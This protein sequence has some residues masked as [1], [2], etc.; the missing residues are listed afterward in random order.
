[1]SEPTFESEAEVKRGEAAT[2]ILLSLLVLFVAAVVV[3]W[4]S[5]ALAPDLPPMLVF[6]VAQGLVVLAGV[7]LLLRRR[8]TRWRD[9][10]LVG[11]QPVDVPRALGALVLMVAVAYALTLLLELIAPGVMEAHTE[12]LTR[13]ARMLVG[14]LPFGF[15]IAGMLFVGF[16]EEAFA[17]G[18]LLRRSRQLLGGIWM[19][20]LVSSILFGLGHAYQ[21]WAGVVQTALIGVVLARL[22]LY[23]GTLWPAILAHAAL[24]T[25]T[26][27][28]AHTAGG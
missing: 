7:A 19:P 28:L 11:L 25:L 15:V 6:I 5:V 27:A 10:G 23:W 3:G 21:G 14:D 8:A 12:G 16:Y 24:N 22:T 17:R 20:V 26:I 1:M 2:D 13:V 18:F 9:I 4:L